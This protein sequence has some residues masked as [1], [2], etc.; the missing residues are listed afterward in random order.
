MEDN[1]SEKDASKGVEAQSQE[2]SVE[3]VEPTSVIEV[4]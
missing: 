1:S 2:L 4:V 3:L